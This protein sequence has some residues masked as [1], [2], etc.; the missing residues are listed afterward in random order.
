M[1][2]RDRFFDIESLFA[3][4]PRLARAEELVES[5]VDGWDVAALDERARDVRTSDRSAGSELLDATRVDVVAERAKTFDDA[6]SA[7]LPRV[8]KMREAPLD[9]FVERVERVRE[10]VHVDAFVFARELHAGNQRDA[11]FVGVRLDFKKRGEVVVIAD[12]DDGDA[13]G[14][15][16]VDDFA[17]RPRAVGVVGVS[18]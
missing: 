5:F 8:A 16:D 10:H 12:R 6:A 13:R 18:V 17:R 9:A 11:T 2:Q 1:D 15:R 4:V 14:A 7:I 3:D